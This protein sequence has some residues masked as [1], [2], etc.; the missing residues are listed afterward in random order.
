MSALRQ[1]QSVSYPS[2]NHVTLQYLSVYMIVSP[3]G[4]RTSEPFQSVSQVPTYQHHGLV[5]PLL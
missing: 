1:A 5:R 4:F 3:Y 2:H